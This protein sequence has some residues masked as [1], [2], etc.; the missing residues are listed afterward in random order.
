MTP[1]EG[2]FGL[3]IKRA[4]SRHRNNRYRGLA[5]LTPDVVA[6]ILGRWADQRVMLERLERP[7]PMGWRSSG[8]FW[9]AISAGFPG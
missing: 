3:L 4:E 1:S 6:A 7:L 8:S 9:L 2:I 5:L